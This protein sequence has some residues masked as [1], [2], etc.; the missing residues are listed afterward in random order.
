MENSRPELETFSCR[1][2]GDLVYVHSG[3]VASVARRLME[4]AGARPCFWCASGLCPRCRSMQGES[5]SGDGEGEQPDETSSEQ[6]G[7]A[8]KGNGE[9]ETSGE[10]AEQEEQQEEQPEE[11]EEEGESES[12]NSEE[13]EDEENSQDQDQQERSYGDIRE[14]GGKAGN[15]RKS[16]QA[17]GAGRGT[18]ASAPAE[19]T[20]AAMRQKKRLSPGAV[21]R[22]SVS[23]ASRGCSCGSPSCAVC[24]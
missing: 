21:S 8:G 23:H 7:S 15:S 12:K 4:A 5:S 22:F 3:S 13:S 16:I 11:R 2:C 6:E 14:K 1:C 9:N 17:F 20:A 18:G 19:K 24:G 10:Q